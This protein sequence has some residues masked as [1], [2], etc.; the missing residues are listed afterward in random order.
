[1][2]CV[3]CAWANGWVNNRGAGNLRHHRAHYDAMV[4]SAGMR[5]FVFMLLST[6][7]ESRGHR[8]ILRRPTLVQIMACRLVDTM[9]LSEPMLEYCQLDP[10]EQISVKFYQ[11]LKHFHSRTCIW[12]Y[13]LRKLRL[14]CLWP[15]CLGF[16]VLTSRT[17]ITKS[18][19]LIT[20]PLKPKPV[21]WSQLTTD[22]R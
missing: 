5:N 2:F 16:N 11:K 7:A 15:F 12:K 18:R 10:W 6:W 1:M 21:T 3:I 19:E 14:F 17:V 4:M 9:P 8:V 22:T 13:R 20:D